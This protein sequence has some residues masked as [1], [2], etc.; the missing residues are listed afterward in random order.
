M[1]VTSSNVYSCVSLYFFVYTTSP[2]TLSEFDYNCAGVYGMWN[3]YTI[4]LLCLYAPSHKRTATAESL[5]GTREEE[6][7]LTTMPQAQGDASVLSSMI[8]KSTID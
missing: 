8:S 4:A 6:V 3:M 7:Q 1:Y 2:D 5:D